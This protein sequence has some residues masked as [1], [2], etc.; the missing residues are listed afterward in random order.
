MIGNYPHNF[1]PAACSDLPRV[2]FSGWLY[3]SWA[4]FRRTTYAF[5]PLVILGTILW[6]Q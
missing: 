1:L 6:Q 4:L 5:L 3:G 2:L